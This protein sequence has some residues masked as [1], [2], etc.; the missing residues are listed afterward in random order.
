MVEDTKIGGEK[1][2]E[3]TSPSGERLLWRGTGHMVGSE[4]M[5]GRRESHANPRGGM[6]G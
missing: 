2:G 5:V 1:M 6:N 4:W 3:T